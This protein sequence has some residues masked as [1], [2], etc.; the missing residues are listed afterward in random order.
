VAVH[1]TSFVAVSVKAPSV[2]DPSTTTV[3][4]DD[5]RVPVR[6]RPPSMVTSVSGPAV[7]VVAAVTSFAVP[8]S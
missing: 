3:C 4:G 8:L 7:H 6:M 2:Y 5:P 1:L